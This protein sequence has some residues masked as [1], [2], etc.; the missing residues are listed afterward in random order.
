MTVLDLEVAPNTTPILVG[1]QPLQINPAAV[2]IS[3]REATGC[4]F[5]CPRSDG[6]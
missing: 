4:W 6:R 5:C 1:A 3:R 2:P